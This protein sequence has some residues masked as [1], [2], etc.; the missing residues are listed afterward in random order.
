V[1]HHK[2]EDIIAETRDLPGVTYCEQK[3]L[4]GTGGALLAAKSFI[5][6]MDMDTV[7]ITMGDVPLVVPATYDDLLS[8]T[9]EC[10]LVVL[11]FEPGDKR[12][13]G[14]LDIR[15]DRVYDIIEWAYWHDFPDE[16]Q[17]AYT[18]CNSGIYAARRRDLLAYMEL[19]EKHPHTVRKER[20]GRVVDLLEYFITDIVSLMA[21]DGLNVGYV[22]ARDPDEVMGIDDPASLQKA[23]TLFKAQQERGRDE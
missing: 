15:Q 9:S 5:R 16:K 22:L 11:G 3:S 12:Q 6:A 7:I 13:Y 17:D 21:R 20:N 18:I 8:R 2:K 23:Q 10:S 19:L 4:D 14:V 1:V